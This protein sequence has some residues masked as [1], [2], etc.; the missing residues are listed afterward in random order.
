[1]AASPRA[2]SPGIL[3]GPAAPP[4]PPPRPG[5]AASL[6]VGVLEAVR[7]GGASAQRFAAHPLL[8]GAAALPQ[9]L[10]RPSPTRELPAQPPGFSLPLS[11]HTHHPLRPA[12]GVPGPHKLAAACLLWYPVACFSVSMHV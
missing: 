7:W 4:R 11:S 5:G 8:A 1:M 10:A 2:P 12:S 6:Q 9:A 3:V